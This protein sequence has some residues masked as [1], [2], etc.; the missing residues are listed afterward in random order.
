MASLVAVRCREIDAGGA[1]PSR[2]GPCWPWASALPGEAVA[3]APA[4]ASLI[5]KKSSRPFDVPSLS[6]AIR[7]MDCGLPIAQNGASVL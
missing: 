4:F 7:E 3:V 6:R 1:P 5:A 2:P